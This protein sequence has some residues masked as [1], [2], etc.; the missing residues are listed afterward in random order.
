MQ[1]SFLEVA[2][3]MT[4]NIHRYDFNILLVISWLRA[5]R[6]TLTKTLLFLKCLGLSQ[7]K[8]NQSL[9]G[10]WKNSYLVEFG[11]SLREFV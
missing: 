8:S 7:Y 1:L 5:S 9:H 2:F 3:Q 11:K 6:N 10:D 4:R